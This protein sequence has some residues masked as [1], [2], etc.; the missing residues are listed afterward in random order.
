MKVTDLSSFNAIRERGLSKLLPPRPKISVGLGTCG[1]G[2]GAEGVYHALSDA[3]ETLGLGF[4]VSSTGCF[5]FCAE[6]PLVNVRIPG[7]PLV[8]LRRVRQADVGAILD[9]LAEG[10]INP[11]R[12]LCKI[13]EWDHITGT[14]RY[15][16]GFP[17]IPHWH[18]T[19]FFKGQK[20]IVLRNCGL[21]SPDDI[22]EYFAVGGYQALYKVLIDGQPELV[23]EQ[24]KAAKLRGR[25][26]NRHQVGPAAQGE[27]FSEVPDLQ[28]G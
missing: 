17:E 12:A 10:H 15:G 19:P 6:E 4:Q 24:I 8:I 14:I 1:A 2:N 5:G 20:K 21:I 26:P 22:E 25:L 18:E 7:K 11:E 23:I 16:E 13:E 3:V 27:G 28:R 9:E